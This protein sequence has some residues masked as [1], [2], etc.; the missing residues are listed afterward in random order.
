MPI[1]RKEGDYRIMELGKKKRLQKKV[2]FTEEIHW[3][4]LSGSDV[5]NTLRN[6]SP[7]LTVSSWVTE[8]PERNAVKVCDISV[9]PDKRQHTHKRHHTHTQ[10]DRCVCMQ[11]LLKS[12]SCL[13]KWQRRTV[14]LVSPNMICHM[15]LQKRRIPKWYGGSGDGKV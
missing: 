14:A 9:V 2:R 7:C 15:F 1:S 8:L 5:H 6:I 4:N 10:I 3:G 13:L 11:N 12:V